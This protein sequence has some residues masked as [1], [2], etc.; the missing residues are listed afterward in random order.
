MTDFAVQQPGGLLGFTSAGIASFEVL[1]AEPLPDEILPGTLGSS[2]RWR[3]RSDEIELWDDV[4]AFRRG[5]VWVFLQGISPEA[6]GTPVV[7][8]G[9]LIDGILLG[10][11]AQSSAVGQDVAEF[12][13]P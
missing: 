8:L 6:G 1:E 5:T 11:F 9:L 12:M 13:R 3:V 4:L 2:A 7:D 10:I